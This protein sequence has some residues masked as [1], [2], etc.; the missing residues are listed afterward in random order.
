MKPASSVLSCPLPSG[1]TKPDT[2]SSV[3]SCPLSLRTGTNRTRPGQDAARAN[4]P[5]DQHQLGSAALELAR[6]GLTP[7][8]IGVALGLGTGAVEALLGVGG[9]PAKG[10]VRGFR[11]PSY[12]QPQPQP[13][14]L[15]HR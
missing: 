9:P 10:E 2:A 11:G 8:D 15:T 5:T 4:R 12:T 6:L 3:L 14:P 1:W 7:R 13:A